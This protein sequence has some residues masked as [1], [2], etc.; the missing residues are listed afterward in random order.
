[1]EK[2]TSVWYKI[3]KWLIWLFYPKTQ[4]VGA[5]SLPQEPVIFVGNHTQLN[6]PIVCELYMPRERYTWCAGEMMRWK[7]VPSYAFRDFWSQKPKY[8][9]WYYKLL[10]YLITPVSV[11]LFNNANT[12]AV[13]RD[14]RLINTFR[15]TVNTLEAGVSVVIFPEHDV[16][17]NHIVYDFQDKFTDVAKLYYKRTGKAVKFVPMYIAP[18]LRQVHFGIPMAYDPEESMDT[19]RSRLCN[20]LMAEI[21]RVAEALPEHTVVP[22]RNIPKKLYPSNK[23]ASHEDPCG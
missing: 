3:L 5:Q 4:V 21:T 12:I 11:C 18:N 14:A 23:E 7:E 10:A 20:Y 2:K 8:T 22:Y 15:T 1:M 9:H 6:G 13:H 19:Q 17:H 16:K